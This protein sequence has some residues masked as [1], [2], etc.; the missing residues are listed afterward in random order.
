MVRKERPHLHTPTS[1][2]VEKRTSGTRIFHLFLTKQNEG[3]MVIRQDMQE[4]GHSVI[5]VSQTNSPCLWQPLQQFEHCSAY[6]EHHLPNHPPSRYL[7]AEPLDL[8]VRYCTSK[9]DIHELQSRFNHNIASNT[10]CLLHLS[11]APFCNLCFHYQHGVACDNSAPQHSF[12]P[13]LIHKGPHTSTPRRVHSTR[14]AAQCLRDS[15]THVFGHKKAMTCLGRH[16]DEYQ[17]RPLNV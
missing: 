8:P 9:T 3:S 15:S 16:E 6:Q 11:S 12:I 7:G 17:L 1:H 14:F 4:V 5:I 13:N 10:N 2:R